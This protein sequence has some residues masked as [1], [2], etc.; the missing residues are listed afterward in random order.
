MQTSLSGPRLFCWSGRNSSGR[1]WRWRDWSGSLQHCSI[2]FFWKA[3][4]L[5]SAKCFSSAAN[6]DFIFTWG[7][8]ACREPFPEKTL[9]RHSRLQW[10]GS[11]SLQLQR[12]CLLVWVTGFKQKDKL[13]KKAEISFKNGNAAILPWVWQKMWDVNICRW[14][15]HQS[16]LFGN[17]LGP[18]LDF[19]LLQQNKVEG[20]TGPCHSNRWEWCHQTHLIGLVRVNSSGPPSSFVVVVVIVIVAIVVDMVFV[21]VDIGVVD[22][23]F[24]GVQVIF[25]G[26][27]RLSITH[28]T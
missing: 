18:M 19:S 28:S 3:N 26:N 11:D 15:C 24:V 25:F 6:T 10:F 17:H 16:P 20:K 8:N 13:C 12:W 22:T 21:V 1:T 23:I 2:Y 9:K 4:W 27:T 5:V 7:E 14:C